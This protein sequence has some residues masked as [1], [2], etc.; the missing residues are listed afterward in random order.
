MKRLK[1]NIEGG[2]RDRGYPSDRGHNVCHRKQHHIAMRKHPTLA[3]MK[4]IGITQ[5]EF[6]GLA[7]LRMIYRPSEKSKHPP[8]TKTPFYSVLQFSNYVHNVITL[9]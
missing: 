4:Q 6:I 7:P 9:C 1:Q 3:W 2:E 5:P 8:E